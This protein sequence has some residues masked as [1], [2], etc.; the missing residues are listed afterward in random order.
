[1]TIIMS[2][3]DC[4]NML[5]ANKSLCLSLQVLPLTVTKNEKCDMPSPHYIGS[6]KQVLYKLTESVNLIF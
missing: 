6:F 3:T 5:F 4:N 2:E 1:M